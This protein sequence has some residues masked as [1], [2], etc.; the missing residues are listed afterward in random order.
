[1]SDIIFGSHTF[2]SPD[3]KLSGLDSG[4]ERISG[5]QFIDGAYRIYASDVFGQDLTLSAILDTTG[6]N[7]QFY[8]VIRWSDILALRVMP[9][10]PQQLLHSRSVSLAETGVI[11]VFDKTSLDGLT[12]YDLPGTGE[13]INPT[14]DTTYPETE[15]LLMW[16]GVLT[17]KRIS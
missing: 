10:S 4:S 15:M 1:M 12:Y 11:A 13:P 16:Y 9:S 2:T 17:F 8:G 6:N 14:M 5:Q 3:L 7:P